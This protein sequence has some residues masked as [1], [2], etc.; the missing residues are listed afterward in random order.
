MSICVQWGSG[1]IYIDVGVLDMK[2]FE[3]YLVSFTV[4]WGE[5]GSDALMGSALISSTS[6]Y[7]PLMEDHVRASCKFH[8]LCLEVELFDFT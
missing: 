8:V 6:N 5:S 2:K 7:K 4:W 1:Q 3:N